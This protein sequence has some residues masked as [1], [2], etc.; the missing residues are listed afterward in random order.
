LQRKQQVVARGKGDG[1]KGD[2]KTKVICDI[3]A[4]EQLA[5]IE[6]KYS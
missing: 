6:T 1:G 5:E 3:M 2:R 4:N